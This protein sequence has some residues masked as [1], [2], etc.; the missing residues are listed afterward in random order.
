MTCIQVTYTSM[1]STFCFHHC[2]QFFLLNTLN[3][4]LLLWYIFHLRLIFCTKC[5]ALLFSV[6]HLCLLLRF[7]HVFGIYR[8][9]VANI[10][11]KF[12]SNRVKLCCRTIIVF[13]ILKHYKRTEN[14]SLALNRWLKHLM[15]LLKKKKKRKER[16]QRVKI[17]LT[18]NLVL[19]T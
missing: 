6:L 7:Q 4:I 19:S 1:K 18:K 14:D 16:S 12:K 11:I 10:L 5:C 2:S 9:A 13:S 3:T 17:N 8:P 15:F